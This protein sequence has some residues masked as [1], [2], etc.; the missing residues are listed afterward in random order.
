MTS[1]LFSLEVHPYC[2]WRRTYVVGCEF[3]KSIV[4]YDSLKKNKDFGKYDKLG[5]YV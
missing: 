5:I 1:I 4:C 2:C 3:Q